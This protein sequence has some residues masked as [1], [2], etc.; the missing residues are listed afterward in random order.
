[1][2]RRHAICATQHGRLG[3]RRPSGCPQR[4]FR[5]RLQR[6]QGARGPQQPDAAD[7]TAAAIFWTVQTAVPWHAAARAAAA[8]HGLSISET[9]RLFAMLSMATADSQILAF[10]E[11]YASSHLASDHR[12]PVRRRRC[13]TTGSS[14]IPIGR[15]CW[16]RRRIRNILR[17][18]DLL[19]LSPKLCCRPFSTATRW[20]SA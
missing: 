17:R 12:D 10:A 4:R 3:V 2:G 14:P 13:M 1:M 19:R 11:K 6:G 8:S 15:P 18:I 16:A 20:T 7:Q 9:A 5:P